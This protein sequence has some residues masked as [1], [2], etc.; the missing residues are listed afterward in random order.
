MCT[1]NI[2]VNDAIIH[3]IHHHLNDREAIGQWLQQQVDLMLEQMLEDAETMDLETA[4]KQLHEVVRK[5]YA[6]I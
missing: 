5:E 3:H 2:K 6:L 1:V 4:H